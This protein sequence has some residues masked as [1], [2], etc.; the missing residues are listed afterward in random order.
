MRELKSMDKI[1]YDALGEELRKIRKNKRMSLQDV[2][3]KMNL[4]KQSIDNYECGITRI[5]E[6]R[7]KQF[8]SVFGIPSN[9]TV[10]VKVK[11]E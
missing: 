1:F 11:L 6:Q 10:E 8:C 2:G 7:F 4:S 5:S 3:H 9:V